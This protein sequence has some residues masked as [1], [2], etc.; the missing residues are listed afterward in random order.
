MYNNLFHIQIS[1]Y[2]DISSY[3]KVYLWRRFVQYHSCGG[4]SNWDWYQTSLRFRFHGSCEH[5]GCISGSRTTEWNRDTDAEEMLPTICTVQCMY[6]STRKEGH[7]HPQRLT[8]VWQ[9][10]DHFYLYVIE[11]SSLIFFFTICFADMGNKNVK[12]CIVCCK[13]YLIQCRYINLYNH[14]H[15]VCM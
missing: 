10:Y 3:Y 8:W 6:H 11:E 4:L 7:H 14:I 13:Y 1:L 12:T 15:N 9:V 2:P 5:Q